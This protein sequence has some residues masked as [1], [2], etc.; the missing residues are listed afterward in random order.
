MCVLMHLRAE[1]N[2]G[3]HSS[4]TFNLVLNPGSVSPGPGAH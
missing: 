4:G 2:L 3:Y 1:A